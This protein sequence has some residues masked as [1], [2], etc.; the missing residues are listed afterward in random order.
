MSRSDY[1]GALGHSTPTALR[2]RGLL[3]SSLSRLG[4]AESQARPPRSSRFADDGVL[5][6]SLASGCA[7]PDPKSLRWQIGRLR[8][9]GDYQGRGP[10]VVGLRAQRELRRPL[11]GGAQFEADRSDS[12]V[13]L[14]AAGQ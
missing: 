10:R 3:R 7:L 8:Q 6:A 9:V 5:R 12:V 14:D 13:R 2:R 4:G 11:V 1:R